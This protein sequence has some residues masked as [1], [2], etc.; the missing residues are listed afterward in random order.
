MYEGFIP[1]STFYTKFPVV[2]E[3]SEGVG[4]E[5][6]GNIE[7]TLI[8]YYPMPLYP[9]FPYTPPHPIISSRNPCIYLPVH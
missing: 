2:G 9:Y 1:H 3:F 6:W 7:A 5:V 8:P 4:V